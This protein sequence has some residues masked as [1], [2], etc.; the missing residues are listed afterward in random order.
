MAAAPHPKVEWVDGT[1]EATGLAA[2]SLDLVLCAQS[3][4][5]FR[6]PDALREFARILRPDGRLALVWNRRRTRDSL[7]EGYRQAIIDVGGR[8]LADRMELNP[9]VVAASGLFS[10]L[11]QYRFPNVQQLDLRGLLGRARSA[12][13]VPRDGPEGERL[14]ELLS[15]LHERHADANGL[16]TFTYETELNCAVRR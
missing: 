9:E 6:Q 2:H 15:S 7:T 8:S 10:P 14:A 3:F 13:H 16:V 1:A 12:S 4:H 5:W 11:E